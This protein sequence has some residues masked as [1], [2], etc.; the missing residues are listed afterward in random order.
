MRAHARFDEVQQAYPERIQKIKGR[1]QDAVSLFADHSLDLVYLDGLHT[2]EQTYRDLCNTLMHA[3]PA[4]VILVDDTVP[5][6][7]GCPRSRAS[8]TRVRIA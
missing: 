5:T 3:H 4:T 7:T 1:G 2:F 8:F 6:S